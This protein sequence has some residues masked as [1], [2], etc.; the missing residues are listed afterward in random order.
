MLIKNLK[1]YSVVVV[2]KRGFTT[3]KRN[4]AIDSIAI[5]SFLNFIYLL[6]GIERNLTKDI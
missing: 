1:I 4:A 3:F 2:G 5:S 6:L